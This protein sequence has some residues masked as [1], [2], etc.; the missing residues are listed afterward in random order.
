MLSAVDLKLNHHHRHRISTFLRGAT[1]CVLA[2]T[3]CVSHGYNAAHVSQAQL[4]A[5]VFTISAA[6]LLGDASATDRVRGAHV[7]AD[8]VLVLAVNLNA[9]QPGSLAPTVLGTANAN[10]SG[11]VV[12]LSPDGRRVLSVTRLA[13]QVEDL[14]ADAQ[15]NL[16]VA[17][18]A[19]GLFKL[20]PTAQSVL[21]Q[22][23]PGTVMRVDAT[24]EGVSAALIT[25]SSDPNSSNPGAGS[26]VTHA[27]DGSELGSIAGKH[28]TL[29][30]CIHGTSQT[31]ISI[32]W[33]QAS[34]AGVPVQI[35]YLNGAS[36]DGAITRYTLYDWSTDASNPRFINKP[37]NNMA[38]TRGYRCA[39]GE[40]DKLYAA[41]EA[42]GGNHIFRYQPRDIMSKVTLAGGDQWQQF[43]N[44][45][46]EHKTVFARYDPATGD[47]AAGQQYLAR[48]GPDKGNAGNSLRVNR[49]AIA[50]D[51]QGRVYI[52]G[53]SAWGLPLPPHPRFTPAAGQQTFNHLESDAAAYI[54]GAWFTVF[55]PDLKTRLYATRLSEGGSTSAIAVRSNVS[56]TIVLFGG[57]STG[58]GLTRT[59]TLNPVQATLGGGGQDAWFGVLNSGPPPPTATVDPRLTLKLYLPLLRR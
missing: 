45:K 43:S 37:E 23:T 19:D 52:G 28:N 54:G 11:A 41:F 58:G 48:L 29:D 27:A 26:I 7:Q 55:S 40:D 38:D 1:T 47:Y 6:S 5:D 16:F 4:A 24:P 15:G 44:T 50:A 9:A 39:L 3:F 10:S 51:A 31:V 32:G 34:V 33:R 35:A 42:A 12:R 17:A 57:I 18:W 46:S 30:V 59:Y 22:K 25:V 13:T 21:W 14:S 53:D 36:L 49:G 56:G 2:V 20:D 8:G